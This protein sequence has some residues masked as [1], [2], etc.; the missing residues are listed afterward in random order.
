[1]GLEKR[2]IEESFVIVIKKIMRNMSKLIP[3]FASIHLVT[4]I[5]VIENDIG[6]GS[7]G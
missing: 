1:M 2:K 4:C 7:W 6:K 5:G 3:I